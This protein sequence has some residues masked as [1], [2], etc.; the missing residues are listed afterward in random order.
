MSEM[1]EHDL[2][3]ELRTARRA[4]SEAMLALKDA[5]TVLKQCEKTIE[6]IMTEIDTGKALV[7]GKSRP[8]LDAIHAVRDPAPPP[9]KR[10]SGLGKTWNGHLRRRVIRA[11]PTWAS[12]PTCVSTVAMMPRSSKSSARS[13][14]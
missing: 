10:R 4:R 8:L 11:I 3:T 2:F 6:D 5:R 14:P 13:G 1:D 9:R 7:N 12:G